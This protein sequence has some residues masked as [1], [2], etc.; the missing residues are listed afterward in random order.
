AREDLEAVDRIVR[1]IGEIGRIVREDEIETADVFREGAG[2]REDDVPRFAVALL[3]ADRRERAL[4]ETE[5]VRAAVGVGAAAAGA[6]ARGLRVGRTEARARA[7][8]IGVGPAGRHFAGVGGIVE[9][10]MLDG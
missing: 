4:A 1:A 3:F 6:V 10:E 7:A 5:A 9:D 8:A 2:V